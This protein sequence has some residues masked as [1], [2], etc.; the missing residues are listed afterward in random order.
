MDWWGDL[1]KRLGFK[2]V[3]LG[4]IGPSLLNINGDLAFDRV[5]GCGAMGLK[6]AGYVASLLG[7]MGPINDRDP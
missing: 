5:G 3:W 7:P 1:Q 2:R 6:C 4:S